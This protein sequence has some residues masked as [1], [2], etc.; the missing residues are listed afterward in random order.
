MVNLLILYNP[1]YNQEMIE[2]HI[3]ILNA[4]E[5]PK[6]AK[7]GF[8]KI[9][10]K[11]RNYE[12]SKEEKIDTLCEEVTSTQSM[13]LFLTDFSSMYVCKVEAVVDTLENVVAPEYYKSLDVE[14][15]FVVTDIREIM[16]DDFEYVRDQILVQFTTPNYGNHT[17]ALYGN[18]YDYPLE[19][20]QKTP[21]N[22]FENFLTEERHFTKAFKSSKYATVLQELKHY[23]FGKKLLYAMHPD[24][25]EAIVG[26][27]VQYDAHK[28]NN[29]YDFASIVIL[30]A[31]AFENESYYLLKKVFEELMGYDASLENIDYQVQGRSYTL[32]NYLTCKPNIGTNK[33]LLSNPK[34]YQAY[35]E[36][37]KDYGKYAELLSLLTYSL[38]HA[39]STIQGIRNEASHGGAIDRVSCDKVRSLLL[40]VG[41]QSI[42]TH[43]LKCGVEH[44]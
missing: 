18:R 30:Y 5:N 26:A 20:Q 35:K 16:R 44:F 7:V 41:R 9:R 38:K 29:T 33:Y 6:D 2:D 43:I 22:Y 15:W 17:Y 14:R 25:L 37:Y 19:V 36:C 28:D 23:V 34:I 12:H 40:G 39:I 10:S 24:S 13:Q 32:I 1:Y 27:E 31:K 42:M 8:G 21:L 4:S 11:I 3:R